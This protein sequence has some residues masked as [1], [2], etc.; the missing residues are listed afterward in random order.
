[1]GLSS[2]SRILAAPWSRRNC[3]SASAAALYQNL[4]LWLSAAT[5]GAA[6]NESGKADY[7]RTASVYVRPPGPAAGA[8]EGPTVGAVLAA[9]ARVPGLNVARGQ[10]AL[11]CN[12]EKYL[13]LLSRFVEAHVDDMTR[14][15]TSLA[16]GDHVTAV[17]LVHTLKGTG[18]TLGAD[19]LS[20]MAGSLENLLKATQA[21]GIGSDDIRPEMDAIGHELAALAAAFPSSA[22]LPQAD[23][24]PPDP[25]VLRAVLDQLGML[26]EKSDTTAIHLFEKHESLLRA[27]LGAR[28][29]NLGRQIKGFDFETA[30][31]TLRDLREWVGIN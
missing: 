12:S 26:L 19:Q 11:R 3:V 23:T 6:A 29:E 31:M 18:A 16:E 24:T 25:A 7:V 13:S 5:L 4:L 1:M 9:L 28:C 22:S 21:A 20:A 10:A 2:A 27:A 8:G 17:R 15:A 14:L 30:H